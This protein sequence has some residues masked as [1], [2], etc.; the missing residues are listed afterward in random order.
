MGSYATNRFHAE[1]DI[2]I[3]IYFIKE[4]TMDQLTKIQTDISM[5]TSHDCDLISLNRVDPIFARQ[6]IETGRELIVKDRSVWNIW[7]AQQF[8]IYPDFQL[9]L[10]EINLQRAIQACIDIANVIISKEGLGLPNTYRH[11]FE[12]LFKSSVIDSAISQ[13]LIKMV[14]FRNISVHDYEVINPEIVKNIV[15]H[16]LKDLENYYSIIF[17]YIEKWN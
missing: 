6:V 7:K 3:A 5:I 13:Q 17:K 11:S 10:F 15:T 4:P 16:Q 1:S 9:A 2:D 12:I 14:G 8:S